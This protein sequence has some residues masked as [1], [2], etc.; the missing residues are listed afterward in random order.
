[1]DERNKNYFQ[2]EVLSQSFPSHSNLSQDTSIIPVYID[3]TC[4]IS[5]RSNRIA[6]ESTNSASG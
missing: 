3:G 1:M 5:K 4:T 6:L 2:Y